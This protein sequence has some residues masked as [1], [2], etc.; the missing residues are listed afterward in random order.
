MRKLVAVLAGLAL[1][2]GI[3]TLPAAAAVP[4]GAAKEVIRLVNAERAKKGLPALK[5]NSGALTKAAQQR[6][7]ELPSRFAHERP[8]GRTW[9]TV[10]P[11]FRV[12]FAKASENLGR[13]QKS[14]AQVVQGWM[15]SPSHRDAILQEGIKQ[16][17][18]GVFE[19]N[20][21]LYWS[22]ELIKPLPLAVRVLRAVLYPF[23]MLWLFIKTFFALLF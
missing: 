20:G 3:L 15:N 13:G 19:K 2:L 5:S 1:L 22:L 10:L 11:E 18:A 23:Q 17:G 6:A 12:P 16:A 8:D 14:A 9:A 21:I 4:A 7:S